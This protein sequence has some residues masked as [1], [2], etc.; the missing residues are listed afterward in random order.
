MENLMLVRAVCF[1]CKK[2]GV[3]AVGRCYDGR[4]VYVGVD[5]GCFEGDV[6][7]MKRLREE[8]SVHARYS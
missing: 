2:Y 5:C 7:R 8:G 6:N 1:Q 4:E 3:C